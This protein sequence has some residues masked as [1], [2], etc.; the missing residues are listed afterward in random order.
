[1]GGRA[2]PICVGGRRNSNPRTRQT[3]QSVEARCVVRGVR[4]EQRKKQQSLLH[5]V[6][7]GKVLVKSVPGF[8]SQC[9]SHGPHVVASVPSASHC[10]NHAPQ[11]LA[12]VTMRTPPPLPSPEHSRPSAHKTTY[13]PEPHEK[14]QNPICPAS[15]H[16]IITQAMRRW[17]VLVT[18]PLSNP[19]GWL[20]VVLIA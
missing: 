4:H 7:D 18:R 15:A 1:M 17:A 20:H 9:H 8:A 16:S 3:Q 13:P 10:H 6:D 5:Q 11:V 12:S 19:R 14:G 2:V